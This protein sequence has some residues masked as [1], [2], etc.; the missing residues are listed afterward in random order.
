[1]A[2]KIRLKRM[3][4]KRKPH[5]KIIVCDRSAGRDSR[6][7]EELGFYDPSQN[8]PLVKLNKD[9]ADYWLSVGVEVSDT[10]KSIIKKNKA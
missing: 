2:A 1:M 9:R 4:T 10:I 3:G 6:A 7:I 5:F 8:P